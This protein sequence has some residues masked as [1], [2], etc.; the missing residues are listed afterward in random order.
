MA[1]L[2]AAY[3]TAPMKMIQIS[4]MGT[5]QNQSQPPFQFIILRPPSAPTPEHRLSFNPRCFAEAVVAAPTRRQK[6][7]RVSWREL[8]AAEI[9]AHLLETPTI[10][11]RVWTDEP[12]LPRETRT[13]FIHRVLLGET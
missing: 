5:I 4:I 3:T 11:D 7:C 10:G 13:A 2:T 1:S 12:R 6:P 8:P 9:A